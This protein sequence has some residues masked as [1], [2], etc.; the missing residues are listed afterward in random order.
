VSSNYKR[1]AMMIFQKIN[2]PN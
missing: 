1:L 2:W